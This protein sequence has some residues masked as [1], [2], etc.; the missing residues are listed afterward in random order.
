MSS[1]QDAFDILIHWEGPTFTDDPDDPGGATRYG[2]TLRLLQEFLD[3]R[4]RGDT[5]K[6]ADIQDMSLERARI[7]WREMFWDKWG[8][9]DIIDSETA[10]AVFLA[11]TNLGPRAAHKAAQ[12]ALRC[13]GASVT[14]DGLLGPITLAALNQ[15]PASEV[16][17]ALRSEVAGI[18]RLIADRFPERRKFLAG[19]LNRDYWRP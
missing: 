7:I 3:G 6:T 13:V 1:F 16:V 12:R 15:A 2:I 8:Y 14:E 5:A 11:S 4:G 17:A 19:W 9:G 10:A 18:H